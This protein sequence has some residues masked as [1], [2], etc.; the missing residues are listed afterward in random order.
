VTCGDKC[1]CLGCL[2]YIGSQALIDCRQN[3]ED[4]K[5]NSLEMATE[6]FFKLFPE[7]KWTDGENN[8]LCII[9]FGK[10]GYLV[11]NS[12]PFLYTRPRHPCPTFNC[13]RARQFI[14]PRKKEGKGSIAAFQ[15][16]IIDVFEA[17]TV[18]EH[19]VFNSLFLCINWAMP[20][21]AYLLHEDLEKAGK[22]PPPL[23]LEW[24]QVTQQKLV[25]HFA[26]QKVS[27]KTNGNFHPQ[28]GK[29]EGPAARERQKVLSSNAFNEEF[30]V[31]IEN[32]FKRMLVLLQEVVPGGTDIEKAK[33]VEYVKWSD[34]PRPSLAAVAL[35]ANA[36][37]L[38]TSYSSYN[39]TTNDIKKIGKYTIQQ[40]KNTWD[41][42]LV[43]EEEQAKEGGSEGEEEEEEEEG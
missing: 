17:Q 22:N 33:M 5:E 15:A 8:P 42:Y 31:K 12:L 10:D 24:I 43:P 13:K 27:K 41:G 14:Y 38:L 3:I 36:C 34:Q 19:A 28:V 25:H 37:H 9:R 29:K 23:T 39:K 7:D 30:G 18:I 40:K 1:K 11:S 6:R 20:L 4:L 21:I 16:I 2:N 26:R 35:V 32:S